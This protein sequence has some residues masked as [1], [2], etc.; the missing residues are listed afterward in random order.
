MSTLIGVDEINE[1][2][3]VTIISG[4]L[5]MIVSVVSCLLLFLSH[6]LPLEDY[7]ERRL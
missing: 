5:R 3:L 6:R 1:E 2:C 4:N 7:N